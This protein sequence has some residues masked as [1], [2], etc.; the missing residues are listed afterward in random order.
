MDITNTLASLIG[1][2]FVAAG[3]GLL[4]DR[5][6]IPT[7]LSEMKDQAFLG[8]IAGILAFA[9][10]G[11]IVAIHNDWSGL[12]AGFVSLFGWIALIEGVLMLAA[13][14]WFLGMILRVNLTERVITGFGV[15][16]LCLGVLLLLGALLL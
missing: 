2:Y 13:R 12:I 11:T 8:Y 14:K 1:L 15:G 3:A 10:G 4:V 7:L 16:T 5:N 6:A 9:I